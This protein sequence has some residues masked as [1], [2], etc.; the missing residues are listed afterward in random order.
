MITFWHVLEDIAT[1]AV[2]IA[3]LLVVTYFLLL[4]LLKAGD[5]P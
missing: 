4:W 3:L 1:G 5:L 2:I